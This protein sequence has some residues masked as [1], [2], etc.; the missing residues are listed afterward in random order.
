MQADTGHSSYVGKAEPNRR[1]AAQVSGQ[2]R[3]A[4]DY[5][6]PGQLYAHFIRS[7]HASAT[8]RSIDLSG[9]KRIHG[10]VLAIDG[11]DA[12]RTMDAIPHPCDPVLVG[13]KHVAHHCLAREH[14]GYEGQ[15]VAVIVAQDR[16]S[17]I[18]AAARVQIDYKV[19]KPVITTQDAMAPDAPRVVPGWDD[20][21][22]VAMPMGDGDCAQAFEAADHVVRGSIDIHR[23]ST[24]PIETRVYNALWNGEDEMVTLYSTT[25]SPHSLRYFLSRALRMA[26][27]R[28]RVIAPLNGG[29]FGLK[30]HIHPEEVL[31]C[32]LARRTR[33]PV[34]WVE[35]REECL[36]FGSREQTHDVEMAFRSDGRILAIRDHVRANI[37]APAPNLGWCMCLVTGVTMPGPYAVS[38]LDMNISVA[39]SNKAP[40]NSA[41]GYGKEA[42]AAAL[43]YMMD[44][45]AR[46][47]DI[48]PAEIR[49]RNFIP[50]D[51]FPIK[52]PTGVILDSG[53]YA[54]ALTKA[55]DAVQYRALRERQAQLR[56]EGRH[57]GIGIAYEVCPE[58]GT[59]PGTLAI[60]YDTA[61][62]KIDASGHVTVATGVTDPGTGNA[63]GIA[64]MVADEMG[65][66]I[67]QVRV[68]QGDTETTPFG[69][70]NYSSR[71]LVLGGGAAVMAAAKVR[72]MLSQVAARMMD[73]PQSDLRIEDGMFTAPTTNRKLSIGEVSWAAHTHNNDDIASFITPPLEATGT[74]RSA[75]LNHN[76]DEKGRM[77][78]Y[79]TFSNG[80][81]IAV[82][83]VD[84]DTGAVTMLDF[85]TAHDCGKV[86]NPLLVEGQISGAIAMG[87]GGI[88]SE[89]QL[90]GEGGRL[91]TRSFADYVMPRALDMPPLHILHHDCPSPHT[92]HGAK[93]AGESGVGGTFSA[94]FNAVNDALSPLGAEICEFPVTSAAVW[95]AID[96]ARRASDATRGEAA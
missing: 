81:Y 28:I 34:K 84:P 32:E 57:L 3:Y 59:M 20:N 86:I 31:L 63:T 39:V 78:G 74:C 89:Q 24:Q 44:K 58:G 7:P 9:A 27:N 17:A 94:I 49:M 65:V 25:Q 5:V 43:E 19:H 60:G 61:T 88:L 93:G 54:G 90:Y 21:I 91:L 22:L 16:D 71:S 38:N 37:G 33:K 26:E 18:E 77:N 35:T 96:E 64:Q 47:L 4:D 23:Y 72:D 83:E 82:V 2:V 8:I 56:R 73:V 41:R 13:G 48:D 52:S 55:L 53:D 6:F 46:E 70:G 85:A 68:V 12:A 76:P 14:V 11:E 36:M 30:M 1:G 50:S 40:W 66:H 15:A 87:L 67:D 80:A 45:A 69:A 79:A 10:V 51:Q 42:A 75:S 62:V 92:P 29:S 95:K